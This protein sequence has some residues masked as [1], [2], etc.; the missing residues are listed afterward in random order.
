MSTGDIKNNIDKLKAQLK[1]MK[2]AQ[3]NEQQ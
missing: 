3:I 2:Y 1:S